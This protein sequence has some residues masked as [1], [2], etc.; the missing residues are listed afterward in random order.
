MCSAVMAYQAEN[1]PFLAA[2][3]A[4]SDNEQIGVPRC[5]HAA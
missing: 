1:H 2:E 4:L 5:I 3:H